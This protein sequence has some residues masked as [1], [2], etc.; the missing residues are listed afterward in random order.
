MDLIDFGFL[1]IPLHY[2][3]ITLVRLLQLSTNT[4]LINIRG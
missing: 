3:D 1:N 4:S 2:V